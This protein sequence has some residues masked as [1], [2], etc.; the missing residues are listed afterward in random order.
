MKDTSGGHTKGGPSM[1]TV[2]I[3]PNDAGQRVDKFLQKKLSKPARLDDD[4]AIRQKRYQ[5][6][7]RR[8]QIS[9]RLREGGMSLLSMSGTNFSK[10]P[11]VYDFLLPPPAARYRV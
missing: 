5:L 3:G 9:D 4:K 1:Q 11:P 8:C 2:T 7:G 6:N 10:T